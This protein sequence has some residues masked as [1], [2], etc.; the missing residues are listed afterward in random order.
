VSETQGTI[1]DWADKTFGPAKSNMSI[2]TRAN[3]EMAELLRALAKDD[4][5]GTAAEEAA[6]VVIVLMRLFE[7]LG[8]DMW[9]EVERKMKINRKRVWKKDPDGH[10]YHVSVKEAEAA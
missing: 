5:I 10:G 9:A 7:Y 8:T 6:D 4:R 1:S 2:A 3:E